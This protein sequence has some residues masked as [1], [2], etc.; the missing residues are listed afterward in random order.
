M[1]RPTLWLCIQ[2][3]TRHPLRALP[4]ITTRHCASPRVTAGILLRELWAACPATAGVQ[5]PALKMSTLVKGQQYFTVCVDAV[6]GD[7]RYGLDLYRLVGCQRP[8]PGDGG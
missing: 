6:T 7:R 5:F 1:Q 4:R 3:L 8:V 2:F